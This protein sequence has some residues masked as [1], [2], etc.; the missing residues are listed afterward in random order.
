M[1]LAVTYTGDKDDLI[2]HLT[3][4][5][6]DLTRDA[7][8]PRLGQQAKARLDGKIAGI[9]LAIDVLTRWTGPNGNTP[10]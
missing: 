6:D 8:A 4:Q 7:A 5:R 3:E 2:A 1:A 10:A 9:D